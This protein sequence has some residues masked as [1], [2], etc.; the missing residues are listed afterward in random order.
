M[1][2]RQFS[3]SKN[4]LL[5]N[6]Q[7]IKYNLLPNKTYLTN[8]KNNS[9]F[10]KKKLEINDLINSHIESLTPTISTRRKTIFQSN[11]RKRLFSSNKNNDINKIDIRSFDNKYNNVYKNIN[12][13]SKNNKKELNEHFEKAKFRLFCKIIGDNYSNKI[14][15]N[16]CLL[17]CPYR[18][19]EKIKFLP[20]YEQATPIKRTISGYNIKNTKNNKIINPLKK[21]S[22]KSGISSTLLRKVIDYSLNH[23]IKNISKIINKKIEKELIL[24]NYNNTYLNIPLKTPNSKHKEKINSTKSLNHNKINEEQIFFDSFIPED[25]R[26]TSNNYCD[27]KTIYNIINY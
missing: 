7:K 27:K 14:N 13:K 22:K 15:Y 25:F 5:N 23:G 2:N 3:G 20:K 10:K 21:I 17:E 11:I 12:I 1:K 18:G 16:D 6:K 9:S 19:V 24:N 8:T 4:Y 26:I